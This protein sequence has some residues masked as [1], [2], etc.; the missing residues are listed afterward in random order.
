MPQSS[1]SHRWLRCTTA[2]KHV[3]RV[4]AVSNKPEWD[5]SAQELRTF[6]GLKREVIC[7]HDLAIQ[8]AEFPDNMCFLEDEGR[9]MIRSA[10]ARATRS[11]TLTA[12]PTST[13][14][15]GRKKMPFSSA[16]S[17][18]HSALLGLQLATLSV[19]VVV[20]VVLR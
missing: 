6:I 13:N 19:A 11:S 7:W 5:L 12:S 1:V 9:T 8:G 3:E 2:E 18:T 14:I 16:S 15:Y 20:D 10:P 17:T 4:E